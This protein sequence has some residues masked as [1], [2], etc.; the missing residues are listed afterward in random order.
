MN[1]QLYTYITSATYTTVVFV[2][3][4]ILIMVS[5]CNFN[6][7]DNP[8]PQTSSSIE[9]SKS[10]GAFICAYKVNGSRINGSLVESIFAEKKYWLNQGFFG[11]FDINCCQSQLVIV[12]DSSHNST[13]LN[14]VPENWE[15]IHSD[16]MVKYYDGI[17]FPDTIHIMVKPDVKKDSVNDITLY[18]VNDNPSK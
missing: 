7:N 11:S 1:R 16:I 13:P 9:S 5:S 3:L 10:H 6:I 15:V 18:K 8:G 14:D 4:G 17:V 2:L 12:Y